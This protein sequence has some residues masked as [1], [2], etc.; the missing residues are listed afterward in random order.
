MKT[1][2]DECGG[3]DAPAT[4]LNGGQMSIGEAC[5][6]RVIPSASSQ[7]GL[8]LHCPGDL[9]AGKC[10][11]RRDSSCD[12]TGSALALV[13]AL[14]AC[15][16][17][18]W[19]QPGHKEWASAELV[20]T[21]AGLCRRSARGSHALAAADLRGEQQRQRGNTCMFAVLL[22]VGPSAFLPL[23]PSIIPTKSF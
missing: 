22:C 10:S 9:I 3:M 2:G 11:A 4:T 17:S 12:N 21:L 7:F 23:I 8:F 15:C 5:T 14:A 18:R 6:A 16:L 13:D 19:L 20:R 1:S